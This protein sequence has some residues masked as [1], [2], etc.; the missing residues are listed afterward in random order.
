[1]FLFERY[2]RKCQGGKKSFPHAALCAALFCQAD[3]GKEPNI[4]RQ[5]EE[6][7]LKCEKTFN[8]YYKNKVTCKHRSAK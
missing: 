2:R 3:G 7:W 5:E 6:K 1:M 4:N 8:V